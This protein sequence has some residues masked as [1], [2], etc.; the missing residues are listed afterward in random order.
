[1]LQSFLSGSR[2]EF[3]VSETFINGALR[4]ATDRLRSG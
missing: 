1:M 4:D 3:L 2:S